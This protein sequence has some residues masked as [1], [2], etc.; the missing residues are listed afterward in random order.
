M[1]CG[2][3]N[4]IFVAEDK[5]SGTPNLVDIHNAN[6]FMHDLDL[7]EPP[8]LGRRFTWTNG[9]VE[10]VWV[11]LDRFLVNTA[12]MECFPKVS[13]NSLPR[14]GS[15]HMPIRLEVG[16]NYS[17]PRPFRFEIVW[18]S[19]KGFKELIQQWWGN[20]DLLGCGAYIM[21]KKLSRLKMNLKHWAKFC[22]GSIKLRKL[23]L[24]NVLDV[25]DQAKEDRYLSLTKWSYE[26]LLLERLTEIRNQ[27]KIYWRQ[28]SWLQWLKE[29]DDNT[30]FFHAV[31]NG[32]KNKNFIPSISKGEL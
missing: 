20:G 3:F 16:Q 12:W 1:V 17:I 11:K 4:S 5:V 7:R 18:D 31:A 23:A 13:Q 32:R 15:D 14:M 19:T 26:Q 9:Q 10:L 28:R 8:A 24:L 30:K 6:A 22:F 21:A 2:N 29:G 25:L 27:E